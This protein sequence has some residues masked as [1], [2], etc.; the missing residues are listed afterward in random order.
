MDGTNTTVDIETIKNTLAQDDRVIFAYLYGSFLEGKGYRDIDIAVFAAEGVG[1]TSLA[2]DLKI[3]LHEGTGL[4]P[5][6]FDVRV[7]NDL[8]DNGDLFALLYLHRLLATNELLVDKN[9]DVRTDFLFR[10]SVKYREC[11]GIIGEILA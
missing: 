6:V 8:V 5:D 7:I 11:E 4:F 9:K 3:V 2:T 10:S 1:H